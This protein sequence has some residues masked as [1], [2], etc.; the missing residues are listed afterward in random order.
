MSERRHRTSRPPIQGAQLDAPPKDEDA[1]TTELGALRRPATI[2]EPASDLPTTQVEAYIPGTVELREEVKPEGPRILRPVKLLLEGL[3]PKNIRSAYG[4]APIVLLMG[5]GMVS[6]FADTAFTLTLPEIQRAFRLNLTSVINL[7]VWVGLLG[8][9]LAVPLG[10]LGDRYR[11]VTMTGIGGLFSGF[12][13]LGVGLAIGKWPMYGARIG[14]RVGDLG[15]EVVRFGLI[16][17]YVP[18]QER[19]KTFAWQSIA[20][21]GGSIMAPLFVGVAGTALG[22]RAPF[23]IAGVLGTILSVWFL[24]MPEP[25]RGY[26]ERK[27]FGGDEDVARRQQE[28]PS[29]GEAFRAA[30]GV[31]TL[32]RISYSLPFLRLANRGFAIFTPLYLA[33]THEVDLFGRGMIGGLWALGGIIGLA[34]GGPLVDR[35]ISRNPG[36]VVMINGVA[37]IVVAFAYV[38]L[39][40]APNLAIAVLVST[41]AFTFDAIVYPAFISVA[42][43]V[44]PARLRNLGLATLAYWQIPIFFA[45]P[46]VAQVGSRYGFRATILS[47]VPFMILGGLI[48][49]TAG[50]YVEFDIRSATSAAMASEEWR[51]SRDEGSAKLLVLR[52]VDVHYDSVQVLFGVDL[53]IGEGEIVALLGTNGAGKS[54]L[55]RAISG[56]QV[57]TGGAIVF[58]GR[59]VTHV[60]PHE[61]AGHGIA[62]TPGGRGIFPGLTVR[63]N[64][65]L[66][67]WLYGQDPKHKQEVEQIFTYFPVL[68]ERIDQIAGNLSGGEQQMLTLAQAFLARPS[69]LMI[70][71]LSLGLAPAIVEQLL[72]IVHAIHERGTTIIIVEQSVNIAL[73]LAKRAVFMEKGEVRFDGPTEE[74]LGRPDIMRAVFLKGSKSL[75]VN[76]PTMAAA[77]RVRDEDR[78]TI[79]EVEGLTKSYG[80]V[81]A[82]DGVSFTLMENEVL[83][84]I[85]PN[86]AGKTTVLEMIS[87]FNLPDQGRILYE[88]RDITHLSPDER[89]KLGMLRRFQDAKLFPSLTL[90]ETIAIAFERQVQVRSMVMQGLGLPQARQSEANIRRKVDTLIE[91]LGLEAYRDKFVGEVSTGTRRVTDL[92]CVLA[93]EPRVLL[94]DE[95]SSGLAQ[96]EAENMAPLL[97]QV[98]NETGCSIIII[99]HDMPLISAV[100]DELLAMD[101]G[102]VVT[103]GAPEDVLEDERV[104]RAYLG[105]TEEV[106][107]RSGQLT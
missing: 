28:P 90:T 43:T 100:S 105:T 18:P 24:F 48:W 92:A 64:L 1:P 31:R 22:W 20:R 23:I 71:E 14:E 17:D 74:L 27:A 50:P 38:A 76:Q 44:I 88:G 26:H 12:G 36:R 73:T 103:R 52:N 53:D 42:S 66:A 2:K 37:S 39:A 47:F 32:R 15:A 35:I 78:A 45:F 25:I 40:L 107:K 72:G 89:A 94:L 4:R 7:I 54:T 8:T 63:E 83:G 11:R 3:N 21:E 102:K 56:T 67:G 104:V 84:L 30:W 95:P 91:L 70:D 62:Q 86:G 69:L 101:L 82:V 99:E 79:L 5:I 34:I 19:G 51:R 10:Y 6:L 85:G 41:L 75:S 58:D 87:G 13:L 106:I 97:H 49:M 68:R 96:R 98:R 80:G 61:I 55:L 65:Q 81:R 29:M 16:S 9:L 77:R 57:A 33:R 93:A 59:D 46:L 60:P